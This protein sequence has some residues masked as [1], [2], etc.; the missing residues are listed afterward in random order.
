MPNNS[1]GCLL[2][3]K[4]NSI[5]V[6]YTGGWQT[7]PVDPSSLLGGTVEHREETDYWG[8]S[9]YPKYTELCFMNLP[10]TSSISLL[11]VMGLCVTKTVATQT[12]DLFFI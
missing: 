8:L 10:E 6:F 5:E 12:S 11:E 3:T 2:R 4:F 1:V 9:C 7:D